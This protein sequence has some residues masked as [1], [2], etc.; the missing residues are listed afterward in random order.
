MLHRHSFLLPLNIDDVNENQKLKNVS[1]HVHA[2]VCMPI[3]YMSLVKFRKR[4]HIQL[5]GGETV[6]IKLLLIFLGTPSQCPQT[7]SC[8]ATGLSPNS[9]A[10]QHCAHKTCSLNRAGRPVL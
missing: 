8:S 4:E 1:V 9:I 7:Q 6:D 3:T 10:Y 2:C 5:Y